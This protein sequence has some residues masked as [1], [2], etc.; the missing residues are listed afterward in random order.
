M[1]D[2]SY[3]DVGELVS[4]LAKDDAVERQ[5]ARE[6]LVNI[7]SAAVPSL[8]DLLGDDQQHVRWEAA[9]TLA[10]IADPT[11][12]EQLVET[13]NDEDPDVRWVAGEALI[14]LGQ[15]SVKPLLTA[16]TKSVDPERMYKGAHHVL[17][18]LARTK[19]LAALLGPVL[20]AFDQPEPEVAVPVA[21]AST[22][23]VAS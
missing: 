17:H 7:G 14:A 12:T 11:A 5:S 1:T 10:A 22:L 20:E 19:N 21:A 8:L 23:A 16:L 3:H 15:E 9:K 6:K 2:A 18:D 13:L 4:A